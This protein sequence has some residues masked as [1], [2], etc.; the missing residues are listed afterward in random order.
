MFAPARAPVHNGPPGMYDRPFDRPPVV[1]L[2]PPAE[3]SN[4]G[5][6]VAGARPPRHPPVFLDLDSF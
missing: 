2:I 3:W 5:P 6:R 4:A 1:P